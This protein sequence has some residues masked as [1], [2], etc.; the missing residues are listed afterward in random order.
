MEISDDIKIHEAS[1]EISALKRGRSSNQNTSV[2]NDPADKVTL[3]SQD[4]KF[5]PSF[6]APGK[7]PL[8]GDETN[9]RFKFD[10]ETGAYRVNKHIVAIDDQH[11]F[12]L[13]NGN[14]SSSTNDAHF[15]PNSPTTDNR[16]NAADVKNN[17]AAKEKQ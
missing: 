3:S 13:S 9:N 17:S 4:S 2:S 8:S 11:K 12:P 6:K 16:N 5:Q 1:R 15:P 10:K 7:L 14:N